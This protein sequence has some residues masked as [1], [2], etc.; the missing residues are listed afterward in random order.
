M[1]PHSATYVRHY[2]TNHVIEGTADGAR[3]KQYLVVIDIGENGAPSSIFL[4]GHYED[5]YAKTPQGWR[6]KTRTFIASAREACETH[7]VSIAGV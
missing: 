5:V 7:P 6:F 3:G 1:Q 4:G 2:L